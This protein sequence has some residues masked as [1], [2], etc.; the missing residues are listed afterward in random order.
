MIDYSGLNPEQREAVFSDRQRILCLAGA[1]TGKTQVLTRRIARLWEQGINPENMLA[2]TFTRAAGAE[3]KERVIGLIGPDGKKLFC[4]TFHAFCVEVI[5]ENAVQ[6]GY[7]PNFSIYDQ[8]ECAEILKAVLHDLRIKIPASRVTDFISGKTENMNAVDLKQAERAANEF[9][10]RLR[11]SNA[12]DF[13]GLISTV[14][15]AIAEDPV[16][17]AKLGAR[18]RH[19]FVDEFQDTDSEQWEIVKNLRPENL[20][21]VGDD[22]QAIYGFRGSDISIILSLADDPEFHT[23]KLERN[24]RSTEP[25]IEAANTL[26]KH[27]T[28]TEKKLISEKHGEPVGFWEPEDDKT[29]ITDLIARLKRNQEPAIART[30]AILART[31]KQ[32]ENAKIILTANGVP[33]E[34]KSSAENPFSGKEAKELLAWI[35]AI[36]NP[37]DED[38]MRRIALAYMGEIAVTKAERM[39]FG[40]GLTFYVALKELDDS[41]EFFEFYGQMAEMMIAADDTL[42]GAAQVCEHAKIDCP[43]ALNAIAA[44]QAKQAELG[45]YATPAD[46]LEYVRLADVTSKPEKERDASKTYL[47][48]VH[49]SKGLEFDEVYIIGAAQG[50]FPN[51]GDLQEERRLFYVAVT[52]AREY[53]HVSCPRNLSGWG[54]GGKHTEHSQFLKESGIV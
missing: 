42:T 10:Y 34:T 41:G 50:V 30:T 4:N 33:C 54:G 53:L 21:V 39:Q 18:Y 23:V 22:F 16:I 12:I 45:E 29:E 43:A 46:L 28:Q 27:N 7:Y 48:T 11:R 52:R 24:Y 38:A 44:W 13:D 14:K 5:R 26:I 6:L 8:W 40:D 25:I 31:N 37:E 20:F 49:G 1:G 17:N 15:K 9:R 47:M 19:V 2:L 35:T 51:R 36:E 32:L 3:M